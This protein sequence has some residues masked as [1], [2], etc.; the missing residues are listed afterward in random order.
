MVSMIHLV[1]WS[2][3]AL[4]LSAAVVAA[5]PPAPTR[6]IELS[7]HQ[8][9]EARI[10]YE[11]QT[12]N[13]I[14]GRWVAYLPEPP[15]LPSQTKLK[16]TGT[17]KS[18]VIAEKGPL[19][20]KVRLI[21]VPVAKP[22]AGSNLQLDLTVQATLR[23]RKL[24][25]LNDGEKPPKVA[26]LTPTERK[27]YTAPGKSIDFDAK[28]FKDW[29]DKKQ[30]RLKKEEQPLDL[31][32]RV[33]EVIRAD[34]TYRFRLERGTTASMMCD[35]TSS[36]CA[37]MTFLFVGAMRANNIP[38]RALVGRFAKSRKE[39]AQASDMQ[40]DQQHVRGEF[41][42]ARV[43]WVPVDP[44][45]ANG[46]KSKQ[47]REFIGHDPGDLL[48]LHVDVDL[49]LGYPDQ[50]TI[51]ESLQTGP[52]YHAYGKGTFDGTFGPT[53]WQ[54]KATPIARK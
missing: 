38:A 48:V 53:R 16:V 47:V 33:L 35:E 8:I 42:L 14:V 46:N 1:S 11:I 9:V 26:P 36:D 17:P 51:S 50:V 30:L 44:T 39:G 32:E 31:A 12:K 37:G 3:T 10:G 18:T 23:T 40:Y 28:A 45:D 25:A 15:E 22:A 54:L 29:L 4:V 2:T 5:Q 49:Q 6:K 21:D 27:F 43:G 20:R 41:Y 24:V 13:F 7:D 19:A 52:H 34:Y